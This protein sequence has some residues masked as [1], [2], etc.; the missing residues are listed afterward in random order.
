MYK[1][2]HKHRCKVSIIVPVYN[3]EK[4][5]KCCINGVLSQ[6]Y[7]NWELILLDD[8]SLDDSWKICDEYKHIDDRIVV[9]HKNNTG[10]ADTRNVGL[11]IASGKYI[12]F[13]D[14]DDYW[15]DNTIV[16]HFVNL[17]EDN[18]LDIIR[19]EY[20]AVDSDG[21]DLFC[22]DFPKKK[23]IAGKIIDSVSF[24]KDALDGEFFLVLSLFRREAIANVRFNIGQIFLEDM[25]F[26]STLLMNPLKCMYVPYYFY[27]YRKNIS[28][29]SNRINYK[30]LSD[31]FEMCNFFHSCAVKR[32][33][34]ELTEYF[35]HYSVMMYKW[36]LETLSHDDYYNERRYLVDFLSL[37][38]L[39]LRVRQWIDIEHIKVSRSFFVIPPLLGVVSFRIINKCREKLHFLKCRILSNR[40]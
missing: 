26:Y 17:A 30:K 28:S 2:V 32:V 16:E 33:S 7:P 3:I 25:R 10:V 19:G 22:R 6:S 13:L 31:S 20:K 14:A 38:D 1:Q 15:Y 29:A 27:A 5:L 11:D 37:K 21:K 40:C 18:K 39:Q 8:G 4:Y 35:N 23:K 12:M 36:T 24:I 9:V 34:P